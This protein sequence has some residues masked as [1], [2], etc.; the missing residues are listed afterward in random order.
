MVD[1]VSKRFSATG[2]RVGALISRNKELMAQAMKICQGRLCAAT[3]DQV[4]AAA[5]YRQMGPDYY[6][7]VR[8]EYRR[9][10]EPWWPRCTSCPD[11]TFAEA[12]GRLLRDGVAAGGRRGEAPVHGCWR[13]SRTTARR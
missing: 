8:E 11:V 12:G 2:A 7:E 9:R 5:M 4:A 10:K 13:S 1:S 3:L 6:D